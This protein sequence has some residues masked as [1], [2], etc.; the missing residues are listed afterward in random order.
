MDLIPDF[1]PSGYKTAIVY[2]RVKDA[3]KALRFYNNVFSAD[4]LLE[5]KDPEG[6]LAH[7]QFKIF[8]TIFYIAEAGRFPPSASIT[9]LYVGDAE[10]IFDACLE[11]GCEEIFPLKEQ[12]YGDK[13]GRVRDPFGQ[14]WIIARH[15]ETISPAE[16]KRRFD[17]LYN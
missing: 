1:V 7:G 5:L 12:F 4:I 8:D 2:L 9:H 3:E 6:K 15:L 13:A 11:N 14:E 10:G 17:E 16:L